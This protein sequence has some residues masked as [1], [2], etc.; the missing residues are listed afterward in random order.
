MLVTENKT[1]V[2]SR[3]IH[4]TYYKMFVLIRCFILGPPYP[5][6]PPRAPHLPIDNTRIHPSDLDM[7][8][9]K[10]F[11]TNEYTNSNKFHKD[12]S[13]FDATTEASHINSNDNEESGTVTQSSDVNQQQPPTIIVVQQ[14]PLQSYMQNPLYGNGYQVFCLYL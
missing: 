8:Y 10:P 6:P 2:F 3:I 9:K 13:S 4:I 5:G 1:F 14:P 11:A 12:P 7:I